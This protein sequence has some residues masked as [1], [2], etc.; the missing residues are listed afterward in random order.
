METGPRTLQQAIQHFSSYENCKEFMVALR[1]RDGKVK[2]P[3]CGSDHVAYLEKARVW[4]CYGK[5]DHPKFSLKTGTIFE[6]S[7]L[8]LDKWL[9]AVWEIVNCR[10][11]I[12]SW[13]LHRALGVTQKTAWF[14]LQRIRLAMQDNF[15]GGMLGGEVEIDESFIGGKARNM[16]KDRKVRAMQGKRGGPD[17]G[18]KTIVLGILERGGIGSPKRVRTSVI[19]D[20]KKVTI[21]PEVMAHVQKG[22]MVHSDE[23]GDSWRMDDR[24]FHEIVSHLDT[25]VRGNVHTNTMENFWSLLKRG[26]GG[27]YVSV[28]PYHLFRYVDEQAFRYNNRKNVDGSLMNDCDR[29]KV[30]MSQIVGKR[31]TYA[32]LT[33]KEGPT[34]PDEAVN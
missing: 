12:S 31:L 20:R 9:P 24:Y 4:K 18:N 21:Q 10:N 27:T 1:W 23:H 33:G 29:F 16:H 11:G 34:Q 7:P 8:G 19:A 5:H 14:M 17:S 6:D 30:A 25:Y 32:E 15:S 22:T 26:I 3:R 2:C 28:E 13:E